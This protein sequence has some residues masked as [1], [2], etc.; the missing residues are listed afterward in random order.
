MLDGARLVST[1]AVAEMT[2][3]HLDAQALATPNLAAQGLGF[4]LGFAVFNDHVKAPAA[5]PRNGYFWGGA[6]STNFWAD[7]DRRITGVV[8]TQVFG[9][10]VMPFYLEMVNTLYAADSAAAPPK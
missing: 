10:D 1:G 8:M 5:V 4:G 7:P 6:A 2:R 9:G 3:N